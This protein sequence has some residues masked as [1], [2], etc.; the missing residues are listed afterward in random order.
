LFN[1]QVAGLSFLPEIFFV[2]LRRLIY[3]ITHY[4]NC[5]A[6]GFQLFTDNYVENSLRLRKNNAAYN[7]KRGNLSVSSEI[8]SI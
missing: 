7:K 4:S 8:L 6:E 3:Y 2:S 5:Q 1:F